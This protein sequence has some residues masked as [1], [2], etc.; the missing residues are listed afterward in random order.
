MPGELYCLSR[1]APLP[2]IDEEMST[3]QQSNQ[4]APAQ[5]IQVHRSLCGWLA[6]SGRVLRQAVIVA[7]L[8]LRVTPRIL[9]LWF[10]KEGAQWRRERARARRA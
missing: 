7:W 3:E 6:W 1:A 10:G 5:T 4:T 8:L 2:R 9:R